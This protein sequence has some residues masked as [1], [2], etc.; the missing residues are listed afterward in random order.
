VARL[1]VRLSSED[2]EAI[3]QRALDVRACPR[4]G[5]RLRL[6]ALIER[7]AVV[8]HIRLKGRPNPLAPTRARCRSLLIRRM[9]GKSLADRDRKLGPPAGA[10]RPQ[11]LR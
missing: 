3:R 9:P 2:L 7:A 6:V 8:Q 5:G 1:N 4:G 11:V 10:S